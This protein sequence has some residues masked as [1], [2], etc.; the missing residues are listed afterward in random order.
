MEAPREGLAGRIGLAAGQSVGS[1]VLVRLERT[2]ADTQIWLAHTTTFP[3]QPMT[4]RARAL[5]I[6][7][8]ASPFGAEIQLG[9]HLAHANLVVA[10]EAIEV[11]PWSCAITAG[12]PGIPLPEL[13][14]ALAA[15]RSTNESQWSEIVTHIVVSLLNGL[16]AAHRTTTAP[17]HPK[18]IVHGGVRPELVEVAPDGAVRL[19]GF[20][21]KVDDD[22]SRIVDRS[23]DA[24]A[25][26]APEQ[27][28]SRMRTPAM[29]LWSAGAVLHELVDGRRFRGDISDPRELYR[30][31]LAGNVA[32]PQRPATPALEQVRAA[33][34]AKNLRDRPRSGAEATT[35]LPKPSA[36]AIARLGDLVRARRPDDAP[37]PVAPVIAAPAAPA[38]VS[39]MVPSFVAPV[40]PQEEGTV[41]IAP[42]DLAAMRAASGSGRTPAVE[43]TPPPSAN[44]EE[45]APVARRRPGRGDI[46]TPTP[47][48]GPAPAPARP[49]AAPPPTLHIPPPAPLEPAPTPAPIIATPSHRE[50]ERIDFDPRVEEGTSFTVREVRR[51]KRSFA[52]ILAVAGVL[53]IVIGVVAG[54]LIVGDDAEDTKAPTKAEPDERDDKRDAAPPP[55]GPVLQPRTP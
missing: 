50:P 36:F 48:A 6:M 11:G 27:L 49:S 52:V 9:Q 4:V 46:D 10:R 33:L 14:D 34:V 7:D 5:D 28:G 45:D 38:D 47:R 55:S 32:P 44:A 42:M 12:A 20:G 19:A 37:P 25:Y 31:A 8:R 22:P 53:A 24:V 26:V 23:G 21:V 54:V 40:V 18:G 3:Q 51:A 1:C 41:A 13:H 39:Q 43:P 29:D 17:A 15:L 35:S 30:I 16:D 2:A